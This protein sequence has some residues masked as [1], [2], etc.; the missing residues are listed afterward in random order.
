MA[1]I[2]LA[3]S[4]NYIFFPTELYIIFTY[5]RTKFKEPKD[6]LAFIF[7]IKNICISWTD[8]CHLSQRFNQACKCLAA[9]VLRCVK[10]ILT[11]VWWIK[12]QMLWVYSS[13]FKKIVTEDSYSVSYF[14]FLLVIDCTFLFAIKVVT[15]YCHVSSPHT[16]NCFICFM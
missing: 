9:S 4:Q 15:V 5:L 1:C 6:L 16:P 10:T 11:C 12:R 7:P 13:S 14:Y 8:H 2:F 3:N